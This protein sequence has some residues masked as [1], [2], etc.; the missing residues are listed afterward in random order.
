MHCKFKQIQM[1]NVAARPWT[2]NHGRLQEGSSIKTATVRICTCKARYTRVV[3]DHTKTL[4]DHM[5]AC[6]MQH[7]VYVQKRKSIDDSKKNV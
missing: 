2:K 3:D 5:C 7:C 4:S 1:M 6:N